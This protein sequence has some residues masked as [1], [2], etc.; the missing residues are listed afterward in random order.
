ML[1]VLAAQ[2][3]KLRYRNQQCNA[4]FDLHIADPS[5]A[6][7]MIKDCMYVLARYLS[8]EEAKQGMFAQ[9]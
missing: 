7:T 3:P 9:S 8:I 4:H 6:L 5:Y 2:P 1:V